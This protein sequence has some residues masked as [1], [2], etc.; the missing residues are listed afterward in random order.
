MPIVLVIR[1]THEN[2][3]QWKQ[4]SVITKVIEA[5]PTVMPCCSSSV[6]KKPSTPR[7]AFQY[8]ASDG[9]ALS[10]SHKEM[11]ANRF[12]QCT[13]GH[14]SPVLPDH[15]HDSNC[16]VALPSLC[17]SVG[18]LTGDLSLFL[19][20]M[21]A[22]CGCVL[23]PKLC[24][25]SR[26]ELASSQ[27]SLL[28]EMSLCWCGSDILPALDKHSIKQLGSLVKAVEIKIE[29]YINWFITSSPSKIAHNSRGTKGT[30]I[31]SGPWSYTKLYWHRCQAALRSLYAYAFS[32]PWPPEESSN[33][34]KKYLPFL[35]DLLLLDARDLWEAIPSH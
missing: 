25:G 3:S 33:N 21:V 20:H 15:R 10:H 28:H 29:V 6:F 26:M 32:W 16:G 11:E 23:P 17:L 8:T 27:F 2:T 1:K 19:K 14:K 4:N 31:K 12:H 13:S 5:A 7:C 9:E 22:I 18:S 35:S 24:G 34:S 30:N